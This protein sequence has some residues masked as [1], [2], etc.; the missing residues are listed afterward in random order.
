MF[1]KYKVF[2]KSCIDKIKNVIWNVD[3]RESKQINKNVHSVHKG[4]HFSEHTYFTIYAISE[5]N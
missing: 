3:S 2:N 5:K 4:K 1:A